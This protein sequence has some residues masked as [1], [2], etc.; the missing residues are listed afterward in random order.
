M[1]TFDEM[2]AEAAAAPFSGWDF[3]WLSGRWSAGSLLPWSYADT[4]AAHAATATTMLDM[5][6]GGGE[7]LAE[8]EPRPP[9]TVATE[10]W[11]PNV[12][13]AASRLAPLA[14]PVVHSDGAADNMSDE[15]SSSEP[16]RAGRLPFRDGAFDLVVNRHE[17]FRADEVYRVLADG[18]SFV[19]QQVDYHSDDDLYRLL[20]LQPPDQPGSWL[21]LAASQLSSAGLVV[22]TAAAAASSTC[23]HDVGAVVYYLR[24]VGWAIPEYSLEAFSPQLRAAAQDA[25]MWPLPV[26]ER[27]FLVV[28]GKQEPGLSGK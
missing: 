10:S 12:P 13:V 9:W 2:V 6:T 8:L 25:S 26:T 3:G 17:S 1:T 21:S 7:W 24:V 5:G 23:F 27:R 4:V 14:I 22:R 18:G 15:A 19:T 11:P 16:G 20:G 28:A